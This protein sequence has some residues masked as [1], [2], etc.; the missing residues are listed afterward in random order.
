MF[1]VT[2]HNTVQRIVLIRPTQNPNM[3]TVRSILSSKD[4]VKTLWGQ[5]VFDLHI[6]QIFDTEEKAKKEL[7]VRSLS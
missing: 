5:I 6:S 7:F 3:V 1:M 2:D 4:E